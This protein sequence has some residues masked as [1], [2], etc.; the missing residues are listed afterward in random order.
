MLLAAALFYII[1]ISIILVDGATRFCEICKCNYP[2]TTTTSDE[3]VDVICTDKPTVINYLFE[4]DFWKDITKNDTPIYDIGTLTVQNIEL[5]IL[6]QQFPKSN[7]KKLDLSF[8]VIAKIN[9]SN[10]VFAN[11]QEMVELDLSHNELTIL[12]GEMFR[13]LRVDSRDYPLRSLRIFRISHNILHTLDQDLFEHL[14]GV[15]IL[16]ISHN[17][18]GVIDQQTE[19]A[20]TSLPYLKEL[21]LENTGIAELPEYILH[22]PKDL[23]IL[24]LSGNQFNGIPK[25][26]KEAKSLEVLYFNQ[27]PIVNLTEEK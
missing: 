16:D 21:D 17:P 27:N 1:S 25:P 24:D 23:N 8:N 9:D 22:T 15:E 13:G 18:F 20:I 11:L 10:M 12:N 26:L 19:I 5:P 2:T 7:L 4:E 14:D 3:N 6:E